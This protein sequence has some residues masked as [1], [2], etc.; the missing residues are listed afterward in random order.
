M[1]ATGEAL[2]I[3]AVTITG[4]ELRYKW[5]LENST[6]QY[7]LPDTTK[8]FTYTFIGNGHKNFIFV[9]LKVPDFWKS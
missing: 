3:T 9:I 8:S 7:L 1:I 2:Q 5:T 6:G 4:T